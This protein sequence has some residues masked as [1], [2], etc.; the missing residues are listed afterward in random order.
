MNRAV[1]LLQTV[2]SLILLLFFPSG[3]AARQP[4]ENWISELKELERI[5][6]YDGS[7]IHNV[8]NLQLHVTNW[9]CFGSY[10]NSPYATRDYPSAQW[11]AN[12]G[13]EYL[14]IAGLWVGAKKGGIAAVST[15]A[16]DTEF[17][18]PNRS[19]DPGEIA[20]IYSANSNSYGGIRF[21][22]PADDDKDGLIDEDPLDGKDNDR[23][24]KIDEDFA[25]ISNQ[26][27][28][29]W[30]T[31]DQ[32][33][34]TSTYPDH[35]P[36][37]LYVHQESYQWEDEEFFDFVGIDYQIIHYS[38]T[39]SL[40]NVYV[41][42]FADGDV[43]HRDTEKYAQ[44]D[45]TCFYRGVQCTMKGDVI[46][47]VE[48]SVAYTFDKD[49]DGGEAP[50]YLGIVFLGHKIDPL[51]ITAPSG[52][53]LTSY[54]NFSGDQP[55][56]YG[57]DPS[58][59]SERYILMSFDGYDRCQDVPRDYRMMM[60]TGPF[61][62]L[63]P[64]DTL[65]LQVAVAIGRGR[66]GMLET[67]AKAA[68]VFEG[69]WFNIDG[70]PQTGINGRET[71]VPGPVTMDPD[72]CDSDFTQ[73]S[74]MRGEYLWINLDCDRERQLW[75]SKCPK[76]DATPES[77]MTGVD[78][79][80]S[81]INWLVGTAPPPPG[82]RIVPGDG[83]VTLLW[84]NFS[85]EALDVSTLEKDF[86]GFRIWRADEWKRPI[87]TT[88]E[89][90]PGKELWKLIEQRDIRNGY[91][92]DFEYRY[93]FSEGGLEYQP[94]AGLDEKEE[95]LDI[96]TENIYHYPLDTVPCPP[97]LT[98]AECDTLEALARYRIGFEGGQK[99]YKYV[100]TEVLNGSRY[101]YAVTA[102]DNTGKYGEPSSNFQLVV[103]SSSG[104]SCLSGEKNPHDIYVVP[105]PVTRE[106]LEP[107]ELGKNM[108]DPSGIKVEFRNLPLCRSTIRVFTISGDLV[109]SIEHDGSSGSN[110]WDLVSRNGQE[111]TSG[112]YLYSVRNDFGNYVGKFV[113]IR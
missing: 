37:G 26:M 113:V 50:G 30:Y 82:I 90:G 31:D 73:E 5:W 111:V 63:M 79:K 65:T 76:G 77:Y 23:D 81:H 110:Y 100:D 1:V 45:A 87:G 89:S 74:A 72:T 25:G 95:M 106:S 104:T 3:S 17:Q 44:D 68:S 12:S 54:Q 56:E 84:N 86:E 43:G 92:N 94:L 112:I 28:A 36:L 9:G 33:N 78:G 15:G 46:W 39:S 14:Y 91:G 35:S 109:D 69:N 101:F 32:E 108:N 42:F 51:G 29:C 57:G 67:A 61:D 85:E 40:D 8:G 99:Y 83:K 16:Y 11:P 27:F 58:N 38:G 4:D 96:F 19:K 55:F 22:R 49:G 53:G 105:N 102:F 60:A 71:P 7:G 10:P 24:G 97:G 21:P 64:G 52:V 20:V 2:I 80:E 62:E 13:V 48:V 88:E 75:N 34:A 59:D 18:P 41:G 66:N 47:P 103:P 70:N 93:P 6:V 98:D 107:W